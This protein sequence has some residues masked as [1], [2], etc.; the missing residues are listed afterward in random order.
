MKEKYTARNAQ[1]TLRDLVQRVTRVEGYIEAAQGSGGAPT[2]HAS[3]LEGLRAPTQG[4]GHTP[5]RSA[6]PVQLCDCTCED[7]MCPNCPLMVAA[8]EDVARAAAAC[9]PPGRKRA[10]VHI[11]RPASADSYKS[12]DE[13]VMQWPDI[14]AAAEGRGAPVA[15]PRALGCFPVAPAKRETVVPCAC[16]RSVGAC[17]CMQ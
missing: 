8:R 16:G 9:P 4:R 5:R 14:L 10:F 12:G 7:D 17:G 6:A 2:G 13:V 1:E 3:V 11:N 15:P